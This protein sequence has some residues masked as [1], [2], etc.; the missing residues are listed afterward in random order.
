MLVVRTQ[1]VLGDFLRCLSPLASA[2]TYV[3][4]TRDGNLGGNSLRKEIKFGEA[5]ITEIASFIQSFLNQLSTQQKSKKA[6]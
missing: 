5:M 2:S 6:P 1:S 4:V 3:V